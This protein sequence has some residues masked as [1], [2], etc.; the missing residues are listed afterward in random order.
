MRK[1]GCGSTPVEALKPHPPLLEAKSP[2]IKFSMKY[3]SPMRQSIRRSLARKQAVVMRAR[4]CMKPVWLSCRIAASTKGYPVLPLHQASKRGREY[5]QPIF[6]YSGLKGLFM[7]DT[8]FFTGQIATSQI[9]IRKKE[10]G[11]AKGGR[12]A[13][14]L[15]RRREGPKKGLP[16]KW[17]MRKDMFVEIPPCDL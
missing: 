12:G 7:L 4:L 8:F 6:V 16:Y 14:D 15:K 13:K 17:P 5:S 11:F 1:Y 10:I 3:R 9:A 2:S